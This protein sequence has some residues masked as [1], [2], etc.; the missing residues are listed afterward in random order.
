MLKYKLRKI[1][2]KKVIFWSATM[3]IF[4]ISMTSIIR[5]YAIT[6]S[7]AHTSGIDGTTVYVNDLV[8]DYDYYIGLNFTE[9][10]NASSLPSGTN[11]GRY[12]DSNLIPVQITYDGTDIN[13]PSLV[14][15]VSPTENQTKFVYYKYYVLNNNKIT[16]DLI[17]NPF[18]ARPYANNTGYG[19]NG[20]A[21]DPS[22]NSNGICSHAEIS[23]DSVYYQRY[24]TIDL[25]NVDYSSGVQVYLNA[26]WIPAHVYDVSG[27]TTL[28][29]VNNNTLSK[30]MMTIANPE[31]TL[32]GNYQ[33]YTKHVNYS[34]KAGITY[35]TRGYYNNYTQYNGIYNPDTTY[36]IREGNSYREA[37]RSETTEDFDVTITYSWDNHTVNLG[38]RTTLPYDKRTTLYFR[39]SGNFN[40]SANHYT[41]AGVACNVSGSG[42]SSTGYKLIQSTDTYYNDDLYQNVNYSAYNTYTDTSV[43]PVEG[44]RR[45]VNCTINGNATECKVNRYANSY[46][47]NYVYLVTRDINIL[48]ITANTNL[49][50]VVSSNPV[51]VSSRPF[52]TGT[53]R[54]VTGDASANNEMVI[55][56]VNLNGEEFY[57]N[58]YNIKFGRNI[59]TSGTYSIE[60]LYGGPD[61]SPTS[62]RRYS[63]IVETGYYY[64]IYST[65]SERITRA[66]A[67]YGSDYDRVYGGNTSA[68]N[69]GRNNLLNVRHRIFGTES[70]RKEADEA[71]NPFVKIYFKSGCV[72]CNANNHFDNSN[73]AGFYLISNSGNTG[74]SY[75]TRGTAYF[76]MD[77]GYVKTIQGGASYIVGARN[78][79][80]IHVSGGTVGTIFAGARRYTTAGNR[81][82]AVTG[83]N[84]LFNV[85]GGSNAYD[86]EA[87]VGNYDSL[88]YVG[89]SAN[90][91]ATPDYDYTVGSNTIVFAT[92]VGNVFGAG[93]GRSGASA[94]AVNNSHVI[95]NGGTIKNDVYG[96]GN[97]GAVGS[98][99]SAATNTVVDILS[100]QING[101]VYGGANRNGAGQES[102]SGGN[103]CSCGGASIC[104]TNTYYVRGSWIPNGGTIPRN[105]YYDYNATYYRNSG[106]FTRTCSILGGCYIY[107]AANSGTAYDPNETYYTFSRV[108][109]N[110][111]STNYSRYT[112]NPTTC[113]PQLPTINLTHNITINMSGGTVSHSV[114]GGSNARGTINGHVTMEMSGGTVTEDIFGGGKGVTDN[115]D[116][117]NNIVYGNITVNAKGTVARDVYGGSALGRVNGTGNTAT[118]FTTKVNVSAGQ[119]DNVYGC[120]MGAGTAAYPYTNGQSTVTITG[121]VIK[122]V[123]GGNNTSGTAAYPTQVKLN[124]G[125]ITQ[126]AYGGGNQ[127]GHNETN[128]QLNG[129][130]VSG[131]VFGGSNQSGTV[132]TANVTIDS[133][134]VTDVFG[135]NNLGGS[136][137]TTKVIFNNA[138]ISGDV[139]GSG[140]QAASTTTNVTINSGTLHNV[141]GGGKDAAAGTS[142]VLFKTGTATEVY[143]GSNNSG[144]VGNSYVYISNGTISNVFG[145]NN[146]D[147]ETQ[148]SHVYIGNGTLG[149]VYGGGKEANTSASTNLYIYGGT[150]NSAFGGGSEADVKNDNGTAKTNVFVYGG[151]INGDVYGGSN[152]SGDV[153]NTEVTIQD[154]PISCTA[155]TP[156]TG[157]VANPCYTKLPRSLN[158][159]FGGNNAGGSSGNTIVNIRDTAVVNDVFGGGN[160]AKVL[161]STTVNMYSG[162]ARNVYGGGNR[163]FVGD[164]VEDADGAFLSGGAEGVTNVYIANGE[165]TK[166][167]YGSGNASFVY[168]DTYVYIGDKAL[169]A[170]GTINNHRVTIG[171]SVF[172]GSET[173]A[174]DA[175]TYTDSYEGVH[176]NSH[177]Y[178][179]ASNYNKTDITVT[180]SLYGSGNNSKTSGNSYI[181]VNDFGTMS[182][183]MSLGSIQRSKY[184]YLTDSVLE[185]RGERDRALITT[186]IYGLIRVEHFYMLGSGANT[187]GTTL[188]MN[189]GTAYLSNYYSGTMGSG[190]TN[191]YSSANFNPQTTTISNAGVASNARSD[192]KLFMHTNIVFSVTTTAEADTT[193]DN[194]ASG[195]VNGMTYL[196]MYTAT[197][198]NYNYGIYDTNLNMNQ[199]LNS[200]VLGGIDAGAYTF[201]YGRHSQSPEVQV[202]NNGFYSHYKQEEDATKLAT[203]Y[204]GVRPDNEKYYKWILG[205]EPLLL[206][207]DL[208]ATNSTV[209]GAY[210]KTI[211][212]KELMDGDDS[213]RDA[214]MKIT[215]IDSTSF[216]ATAD[217]ETPWEAYLVDR[218][219]VPTVATSSS[220]INGYEITD[221]NRYFSLS[222]GT[223]TSGW[224]QNYRTNIY[225]NEDLY[226]QAHGWNNGDFNPDYFMDINSDTCTGTS[227]K[228]TGD[229]EY[230]YD[231]TTNARSL[232]FWLHYSKNLD[233]SLATTGD[234][235]LTVIPLGAVYINTEFDNPHGD[236]THADELH[237]SVMIVVNISM[238]HTNNKG[239]A[240]AIDAGKKYEMFSNHPNPS[241]TGDSAVSIYQMLTLDLVTD[242]EAAANSELNSA[243]TLYAEEET[244]SGITTTAAYRYLKSDYKFPIGTKITMLDLKNNEQ[245]YYVVENNNAE[246]SLDGTFY[247]YRLEDFMR[248]GNTDSSVTFDDDMNGKDSTKYF[249]PKTAGS[250]AGVAV[251]EFIFT[252]DFSEVTSHPTAGYGEHYLYMEIARDTI[253]NGNVISSSSKMFPNGEP[254]NSMKYTIVNNANS[255]IDT[256]G[257]F[258]D[259]NGQ[260]AVDAQNNPEPV[261]FYKR[262]EATLELNTDLK[263]TNGSAQDTK[264]DDYKLGAK[265]TVLQAT[266]D[267]NGNI[268]GYA[269][270]TTNLF[271]TVV[272]INGKEYY[273][274]TDGT[275]RVPMAGRITNVLSDIQLD[276]ENSDMEYG[277][278]KLVVETFASYDGLYYG[279]FTPTRNEFIFTLLNDQYGIDVSLP[280]VEVTRDSN[281]GKDKNGDLVL[282]YSLKTKN[283]LA[284]PNVKVRLERRNYGIDYYE[285]AYSP[286]SLGN[287]ATSLNLEGGNNVMN[288]T[289][290]A[291]LEDGDCYIYNLTSL[292]NDLEEE[293]LVVQM[294]MKEGPSETEINNPMNAKWKSGTYRVVFEIYDGNT[295]IGHVYE[296]LII[297]SLDVDEEIEGS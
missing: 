200:D 128:I 198:S 193:H 36:Y 241:I 142:N 293:D 278:Y 177:V 6:I 51:T 297:R 34:F 116:N 158:D 272:K 242:A 140:N 15:K 228:C 99:T 139:Y 195:P 33:E 220:T 210:L 275:I 211:N 165:I 163:S 49:N 103:S 218:T 102:Q 76:E 230:K 85:F 9:I 131:N 96:G 236:P 146:V 166:N 138:T 3:L 80:A 69:G 291:S 167:V 289:C 234:D 20:W 14:G 279:D 244:T 152:T 109:G 161:T 105:T 255:V 153:S 83:G 23:Y 43:V 132:N 98:Q 91:G 246:Q 280:P 231:S 160:E 156:A 276:F 26:F 59:G 28:A 270:V 196:G 136:V 237:Q 86:Q 173:N 206:V 261:S 55:E 112:V 67:V 292:N 30:T 127:V 214:T 118:N 4:L 5:Y 57:G 133:G 262:D 126:N 48:R 113:T 252:V 74:D 288:G 32:V 11:S 290:F 141:Y 129:S 73:E 130:T 54:N 266:K 189:A 212:L 8:K 120:G 16:I 251:E 190:N 162:K 238:Y 258:L 243:N 22:N 178:L 164:A 62:L 114:Y 70:G 56:D 35:Y 134:S 66:R 46:Y 107:D 197:G 186:Y 260:P 159:V 18:G 169:A 168:G 235:E 203:R 226:D 217:V 182:D 216:K 263:A 194:E 285:T 124:G 179:G 154:T 21:C 176:G 222:M 183:V 170:L 274:Q 184:V 253:E 171:G 213:W 125:T 181:Y 115:N 148:N 296:Y 229:L 267:Q 37:I 71:I 256:T 269:P 12:N 175:T 205:E 78:A 52:G 199:S 219:K 250:E 82:V 204:V 121:G 137:G 286:V 233:F 150:M 81:I 2:R 145:G 151:T 208:F 25:S 13:N 147:G 60:S 187:A 100:G 254:M 281:T 223:T 201:V 123:F 79:V 265:I 225:D 207:V 143:G 95:I 192:N 232:A 7:N 271:G 135:G 287:I 247:K 240:S 155:T 277:D 259:E 122:N 93:N 88:V 149:I 248:M 257:Y 31:Q 264:F 191:Q 68:V 119:I 227:G 215:S 209:E 75:S 41:A 29:N 19:F 221:A 273:P 42:C 202:P 90:I 27:S 104:L 294:T 249:T 188:H 1:G 97:Y 239:Y 180:G 61:A 283:G 58:D 101:N 157:I 144:L 17:D 38:T 185:L 47:N 284:N 92:T 84:V 268:T 108:S 174:D 282:T 106:G 24:I 39:E 245:Y 53:K 72:G 50:R 110:G 40:S 94:G 172:G 45:F 111:S 64:D 77:G 117:L 44:Q 10:T 224:L 63:F 295:P 65:S 87:G 89:G